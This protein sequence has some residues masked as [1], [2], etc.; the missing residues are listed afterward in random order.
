MKITLEK[1]NHGIPQCPDI[2]LNEKKA[3]RTKPQAWSKKIAWQEHWF[4]NY[5]GA[6]KEA[7][8]LGKEVPTIDQW[9]AMLAIVP[10]NAEEKAQALNIP[11]TGCRDADGDGFCNAD[12]FAGLWS[13]SPGGDGSAHCAIL[14]RGFTD[15]GRS[16]SNR[17]HGMSL[18]F[19]SD[20][21]DSSDSSSLPDNSLDTIVRVLEKLKSERTQDIDDIIARIH[22]LK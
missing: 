14:G 18:R 9:M 7:E 3:S 12:V 11:L 2:A 8:F 6:C 20:K 4:Y 17:E 22:N 21:S 16:W 13:S 15:A 1:Q 19:L 10:G 5:P